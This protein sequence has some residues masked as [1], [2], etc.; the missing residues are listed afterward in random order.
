MDDQAIAEYETLEANFKKAV[1]RAVKPRQIVLMG[2]LS[3]KFFDDKVAPID[4]DC[5]VDKVRHVGNPFSRKYAQMLHEVTPVSLAPEY[6][7][8]TKDTET[9]GYTG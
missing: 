2:T 8:I 9:K 3:Q 1:L 4:A 7:W 5:R 6:A